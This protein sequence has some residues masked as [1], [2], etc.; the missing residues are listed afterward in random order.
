MTRPARPATPRPSRRERAAW[1]V[2]LTATLW[3]AVL[4]PA[5][6]YIDP[7]STSLIFS[8]IVAGAAAAGMTLRLTWRRIVDLFRPSSA[9]ASRA[10]HD[11][12]DGPTPEPA[13]S[14]EPARHADRS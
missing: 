13:A 11:G 4:A 14:A 6:A 2:A 10:G 1:I 8:A 3:L 7:G 9:D 12:D 5:S